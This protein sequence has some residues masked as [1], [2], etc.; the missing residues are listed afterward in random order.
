MKSTLGFCFLV[1]VIFVFVMSSNSFAQF[2]GS[3]EMISNGN[4]SI[5]VVAGFDVTIPSLNHGAY[6]AD[7]YRD[8][9]QSPNSPPTILQLPNGMQAAGGWYFVVAGGNAIADF[10]S[11]LN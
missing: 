2:V 4:G 10:Q 5:P 7:W 8:V 6:S 3:F 9:R 11:A 1:L